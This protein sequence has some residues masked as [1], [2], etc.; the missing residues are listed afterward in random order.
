M[1]IEHIALWVKDLEKMRAFYKHYFGAQSNQKYENPAKKFTSYFLTFE[2][3]A[4]L[5]I[6]HGALM[7]PSQDGQESETLGMAHFAMATGSRAK[8][9]A[10]TEQLRNDGYTVIG[11][12]RVTGDGYYESV[13]LDPENNRIEITA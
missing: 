10:L 4:R 3:G 2:S 9:D 6:M 13:V 11:A 8:V 1:K 7:M 12:P 5:E